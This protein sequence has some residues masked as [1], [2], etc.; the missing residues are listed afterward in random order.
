MEARSALDFADSR[1]C[2]AAY[3]SGRIC[4]LLDTALLPVVSI[5]VAR[6]EILE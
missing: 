1:C 3:S 5:C 6:I 4:P 2:A